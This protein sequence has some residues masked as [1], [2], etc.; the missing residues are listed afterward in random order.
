MGNT[1]TFIFKFY[2][3][4]NEASFRKY[5]QCAAVCKEAYRNE[6]FLSNSRLCMNYFVVAYKS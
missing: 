2:A 3:M 1:V 4:F 6:A 5:V